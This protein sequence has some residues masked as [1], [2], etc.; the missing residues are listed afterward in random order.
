MTVERILLIDDESDIR[1]IAS[2]F[3]SN[4]VDIP[5]T[6]SKAEENLKTRKYDVILLDNNFKYYYSQRE[7]YSGIDLYRALKNGEL[8]EL[9]QET[10]V[11]GI[12]NKN[13]PDVLTNFGKPYNE[14]ELKSILE[15]VDEIL[16]AK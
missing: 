16:S 7:N 13:M 3:A 2:K 9:N 8:G 14:K 10:S 6:L 12:S 15:R 11:F 1:A 4:R 5:D